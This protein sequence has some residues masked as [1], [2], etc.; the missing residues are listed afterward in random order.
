M[1]NIFALAAA[2]AVILPSLQAQQHTGARDAATGSGKNVVALAKE[3][4]RFSTLVAAV[5]TAGLAET[6]SGKGPF[7]VFAPTDAAFAKLGKD[8]LSSLLRP[9]NKAKLTSIL[10]YHVV[11]GS[12]PAGKVV[13]SEELTSLQGQALRVVAGGKDGKVEVGGAQVVQTDLMAS[14]GVIH[15][16]DR[17]LLPAGNIVEVAQSAGK[18]GTL[19]RAAQAAGLAET[20]AGKG[21]FTVFAPTDE[22]FAALGEET[23]ASLLQPENKAKLAGILKLHVVSGRVP[24][25][26]AARLDSADTLG[27]KVGVESKDDA[28]FVGG[29][30]VVKPDIVAGNG[31]IHVIDRV[32]VT[33]SD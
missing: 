10:T 18:F 31:I 29:A 20:L 24:S 11:S 16:I 12:L 26:A 1:N 5:E 21:P 23:M 25:S 17:V 28:L 9:E 15:V 8:T 22:A 27:G 33:A 6:L 4:G 14:N 30:R 2:A 32:I 13:A 19:L 7:T 3:A